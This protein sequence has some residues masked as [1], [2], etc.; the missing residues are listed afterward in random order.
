MPGLFDDAAN[1]YLGDP[2]AY[3]AAQASMAMQPAVQDWLHKVVTGQYA[4]DYFNN[5]NQGYDPNRSFAQNALD[6]TLLQ[7]A[8]DLALGFSGGGLATKAARPMPAEIAR[9]DPAFGT[10]PFAEAKY[11]QYAEQ[12]PPV[13]P[14]TLKVGERGNT[15]EAKQLTPEAEAFGQDRLRVMKD[16]EAGYTPYFDPAQRSYVDPANYPPA[17]V[18]TATV[19]PSKAATIKQY[20]D[21][22]DAPET[23]AA[24][25]HAYARGMELGN[26]DHWYAMAQLEKAYTD[27]LG[28]D[29]GRSA[30]LDQFAAPMAATTSGQNPTS[31][32]LMSH[33]LEYSRAR[34]DPVPVQN[35]LPYP[36]GG[37]YAQNNLDDYVRMRDA[38]GYAGLGA[39]QPKMHDFARSMI[40]DLS[41]PVMDDQMARGLLAHV[42]A[43]VQGNA[44]T[45]AYGMLQ[46]P[47]RD[48]AAE[49]GVPPGNVQDV[50][51]A[52]FKNEAGG[53]MIQQINDSIERTHRL[54]GM[55]RDEIVQRGLVNK[56]IPLYGLLGAIGLGG[57]AAGIPDP[58]TGQAPR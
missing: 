31:N 50:A 25:Q 52:G 45:T 46:Q 56:Q 37:R 38:G 1:G 16:M 11:P 33:F 8:T 2:E 5:L 54:T 55:P 6:P 26:T 22:I 15:F 27:H 4:S 49:L 58:N 30:F 42:P 19:R 7:H 39:T 53:P 32:F 3:G 17:N 14:P 10:T 36:V 43:N 57:A 51:W 29:A 28:A 21:A 41:N 47:V 44:R 9:S 12:Y 20:A 34:G 48:M 23:A 40:G 18:D 35:Q 13:G 24:L